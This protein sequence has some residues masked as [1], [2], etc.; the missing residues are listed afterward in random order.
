MGQCDSKSKKLIADGLNIEEE[1]GED[2]DFDL[3]DFD[4][5]SGIESDKDEDIIIEQEMLQE[6]K[7]KKEQY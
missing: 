3:H 6:I 5:S 2:E 4:Y 1:K 7:K